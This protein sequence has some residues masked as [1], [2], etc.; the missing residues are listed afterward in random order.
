MISISTAIFYILTFLSV[1]VQIFFLVTFLENRKKIVIRNEKIKLTA[2]PAVT[3]VVP[4]WNEESTVERTVQSLL[5]LNYP[6][7]K[8][9]IFLIDDGSTDNTWNI[10]NKFVGELNVKIFRKANEGKYT[11]LNLGLKNLQTDFFGCLDADSLV[12]R[13][14]L[15]RIMSYFEKDSSV[16]AVVPSM[17][18][19]NP[20]NFIQYAQRAEYNMG[21]YFKK[22]LSFLGAIHVT[23]GPFTIFRKEVFDKLGSYRHGHSTEDMEIAFRMQKNGYKIDHC[24]DAYV[25]TG[26]P[27][28]VLKLYKQRVR[29]IYGFINNVIDYRGVLF[30]KKYGNFALFTLPV[31]IISSFS[32]SYLF[33]NIVYNLGY[34]LYLK[35]IQL[36]TIGFSFSVKN[37]SLDLFF[38][39]TESLVFLVF[40]LYLFVLF[41]II[42]G[43]K[44]AKEKN[45]FSFYELY[46]FPVFFIIA[47]FWL[48]TG[49]YNTIVSRKPAWR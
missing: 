21:I 11:A 7:E 5:H 16:M 17:K 8:I 4:C 42:F 36:K 1:Y 30:K 12:D 41:A 2:Y 28:S 35:I 23:S 31:G 26:T 43:R 44:M 32:V 33:G 22:M 14:S 13:E 27:L 34:F 45:F 15:V 40:S 6:K 49:I 3:I 25:Y 10:I 9:N 46:Y 38:L 39:N 19:H 29:W 24:N 37:F 47:P 18:V 48:V 20:K